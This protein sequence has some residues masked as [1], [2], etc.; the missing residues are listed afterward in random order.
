LT[1]VMVAM[2]PFDFQVH[3][4]YFLVAH[5]HYVLVGGM[6]FPLFAT[7]YYWAPMLSRRPLSERLGR[8]SFGLMFTGFNVAFFPMHIT[9]LAGMPRRVWTYQG[10]LGWDTL[11][12][13]ST[14]GAF[15]LAAGVLV[16]LIDLARNFR[17]SSK[18]AGN[19]WGAGTLEWLESDVYSTRSI[20]HVTSRDPLWDQPGLAEEVAAGAH[21]L[22]DAPTGGRETVVTSAVEARPQYVLQMPG[23]GWPQVLA[24]VF[25][26]AC[27]LLLTVKLVAI[28]L[29]CAVL[30]IVFIVVWLWPLDP[31]PA[32]GHVEIGA[33]IR[34]PTYM[35]GPQSH[36]WWA[37]VVLMLVAGSLYLSYVF[38]Y[39][40]LWTVS[41]DVWPSRGVPALPPL[42]SPLLSA[43]LCVV[44]VLAFAAADRWLP[45]PGTR[46]IVPAMLAVLVGCAALSAAVAVEIV[47]HWQSGLE[48]GATA[49]G[50][51]VYLAGVLAAQV[52]AAVVLMGLFIV[53]R[54][55]AGRTDR[56]R[57][58]S[59]DH[60]ALLAYYA[61]AQT[62]L[63]L[64][65]VHG[66]PRLV[67]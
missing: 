64:V 50:A 29:A 10:G 56:E 23:N 13:V 41:P 66:F 49:Y 1:G 65:L 34:L 5:F 43:A 53:A 32:K 15:I 63:G 37:M 31:G 8:W 40:Y 24:A 51:M 25:T 27:F 12:L 33:G 59:F 11:N 16:F 39:L 3:D 17:P 57:R 18:P 26:A 22:P 30:A 20:P 36:G 60:T 67:G 19:V 52:V 54:L 55:V 42:Q 7:F 4:T 9:G 48:P 61:A 6:V 45:S 62:L 58:N 2:V 28:S 44:A 47:A 35:T 38:S 21:Y 46:A 14:L